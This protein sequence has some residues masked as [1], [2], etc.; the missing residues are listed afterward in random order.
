MRYRNIRK[1]RARG[2][3]DNSLDIGQTFLGTARTINEF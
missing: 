2:K 3:K 1:Y